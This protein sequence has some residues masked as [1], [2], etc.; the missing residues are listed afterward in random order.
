[1]NKLVA[2][3]NFKKFES[4]SRTIEFKQGLNI[5]YGES[6]TGKSAI[7]DTLQ[8]KDNII[9]KNFDI[10]FEENSLDV[11]RI[12]QNPDHQIIAP[13]ISNE[14]TFSG[15]CKQIEPDKLE[16]ILKQSL[17]L[18]PEYIDPNMNPAYLSGGEKEQLNI[19]TAFDLNP[20]V[21][22]INDGLCFLSKQSKRKYVKNLKTFADKEG[23]IV[24]WVTSDNTDTAFGDWSWTL[25]LDSINSAS[26]IHDQE[27]DYLNIPDGRLSISTEN[28]SFKYEESRNIF[29]GLSVDINKTRSLGL[30]GENGSGKTTFAGFCFGDLEPSGGSI[31]ISVGEEDSPIIGYLD[32]FP[33]HLILLKTVNEFFVDLKF[34]SVFDEAFEK[35]F[36]KRLLRFGIQWEK[37]CDKRGRDLPWVVLRTLLIVMMCHCRFNV[38]ILDEPTFGLGWNQKVKLRSFLRDCMSNMHFIIISHDQKFIH[39]ICDT[40]L[41]FNDQ[42]VRQVSIGE[43]KET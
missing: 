11:Y 2:H 23:C 38:L 39:S 19:V 27:F 15:E 32:Q 35:T 13:T 29:S 10:Y 36:F 6:G 42:K 14:I 26:E 30:L 16:I 43:R 40:V 33:E 22:L 21:L 5:V 28:L 24:I 34:N 31:S 41:D 20:D 8:N 4:E 37:V 12:Y 3:I 7:L 17:D 9:D 1:M 25:S 18:L